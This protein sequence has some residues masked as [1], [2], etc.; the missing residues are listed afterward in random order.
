M[1]APPNRGGFNRPGYGPRGG[2]MSMG[3]GGGTYLFDSVM[4]TELVC[5]HSHLVLGEPVHHVMVT[6]GFLE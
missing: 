6:L 3:R 1:S 2:G 4:T 5:L